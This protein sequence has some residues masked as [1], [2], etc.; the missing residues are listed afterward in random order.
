MFS[1]SI[2]YKKER[3]LR[4]H[5][6]NNSS[7]IQTGT[8]FFI[9][10]GRIFL[11]C[12]HVIFGTELKNLR[13]LPAFISAAGSTEHEKL[14]NYFKSSI[15]KIEVESQDS[16]K[17]ELE[18]KDFNESFDI[19]SLKI[20]DPNINTDNIK[21]CVMKNDVLGQGD[22]VFFG[23]FPVCA[24][25]EAI[26]SPFAINIGMVS[27]FPKIIVGGDKYEHIQINTINLGGNSGA[28]LFRLNSNKVIGI[29][30]GNMNW[31]RDDLLSNENIPVF[32]RVPLSIAYATSIKTITQE[33]NILK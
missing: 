27:S 19:V 25:Y 26:E 29:I 9:E 13:V 1:N 6:L 16:T 2:K 11:T 32:F 28:P 30:N 31:G 7:G 14:L 3:I 12:F 24:G 21:S 17:Y 33:T 18:L 23:G 20:K 4:V 8:G 22:N 15:T 5:V 10:K